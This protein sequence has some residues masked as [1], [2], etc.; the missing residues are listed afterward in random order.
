MEIQNQCVIAAL[1]GTLTMS[2]LRL[3]VK[4]LDFIPGLFNE[5]SGPTYRKVQV[6]VFVVKNSDL[7]LMRN[8]I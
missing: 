1:V 5:D 4:S 3:M 7:H 6:Q 8:Y 2:Y